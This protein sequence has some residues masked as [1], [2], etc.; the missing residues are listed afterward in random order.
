MGTDIHLHT[1][2]KVDGVWYTYGSP[3]LKRNYTLFGRLAG[4]RAWDG[5]HFPVKGLPSDAAVVT[6]KSFE[7][8]QR[9]AHT[10]SY[11]NAA[12]IAEFYRLCEI[13]FG[14][15]GQF[16]IEC[17]HGGAFRSYDIGYLGGNGWT[18]LPPWVEDVRWVFWFD[19]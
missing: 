5:W 18:N 19:C 17:A 3:Y 15:D 12:E 16:S 14:A 8:W 9:D 13:E 11:L 10:A 4:V 1:E 6:R 7:S 2:V